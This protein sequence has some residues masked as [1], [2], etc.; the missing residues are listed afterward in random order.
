L[1]NFNTNKREII[2]TEILQKL[3]IKILRKIG[4]QL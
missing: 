4:Q 2:W 1:I 3:K